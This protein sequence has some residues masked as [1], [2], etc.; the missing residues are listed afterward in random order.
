MSQVSCG[1]FLLLNPAVNGGVQLVEAPAQDGIVQRGFRDHLGQARS[2]DAVIGAGAEQCCP[3][4]AGGHSVAVGAGHT[5][6]QPV[7][8]QAAQV[9]SHLARGQG[10]RRLSQKRR[11]VIAQ[12]AV[13]KT[14]GQQTKHQQCTQERL[15]GAV[16]EAQGASP[17]FIDRYRLIEPAEGVLAQGAILA[18]RLDVQQ[19]SVGLEADLPQGGQVHQPLA[20]AEVARVVD[21]SLGPQGAAFLV[22]LLDARALVVDVQRRRYPFRQHARAEASRRLGGDAS[23]EDQLDLVGAAQVQVLADDL[24]EEDAAGQRPVQHLGQGEFR[25]EDGQ[26]VAVAGLAVLICKGVRQAG[27]PLAQQSVDF[28]TGQ[29]V[30]QLLEALGIGTGKDAVVEGLE[31]N[32]LLGQLAFDVLVAVNT[33]LGVVREVGAELEEERAEVLVDAVKV[34]LVDHGRGAHDPGVRLARL[35]VLA[36]LGAQDGGLLLSLADEADAFAALEACPILQGNL[37]LALPRGEG[38]E[39]DLVPLGETLH[40]GDERLGQGIHK[41][42]RS[43]GVT[44]MGAEEGSDLTFALEPGLVDVEVHA[45]DALDLQGNMLA[46]DFGNGAWYTHGWLRSSWSFGTH[47]PLRGFIG[48]ASSIPRLRYDRSHL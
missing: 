15:H 39:R 36:L 46:Q 29:A 20:Q 6:D 37:L 26:V 30:A 12:V 48:D 10:F 44:T 9:I 4:A 23:S 35:G 8:A 13:G 45:V 28:G 2:Q 1:D 33:E 38:N 19:T 43:E 7:Q 11:P 40:A 25:L 5:L 42:R 21:G 27:Q 3:P 34:K 18:D 24:L 14:S 17:L 22:V 32:A 16:R 47:Q 31:G 41:G